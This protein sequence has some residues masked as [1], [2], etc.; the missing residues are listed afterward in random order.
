[1]K[2][3]L[4]FLVGALAC[5][6]LGSGC[7][8]RA[9]TTKLVVFYACGEGAP[10]PE[11][12]ELW[13]KDH[14]KTPVEGVQDNVVVL[15]KRIQRGDR[16]DVFLG[17]GD[18]EC[19]YLKAKGYVLPNSSVRYAGNHIC[20]VI[21]RA[22]NGTVSSLTD[23]EK[24]SV[25]LVA[26]PDPEFNSV[27]A[28]AVAILKREKLWKQVKPKIIQVAKPSEAMMMVQ[29]NQVRARPFNPARSA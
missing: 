19:Q 29:P 23:L 12:M 17:L 2:R 5:T 22:K 13:N 20:V 27:G 15:I 16:A 1:M 25:K 26:L 4:C 24:P 3:G 6:L 11:C 14:K 28:H 9:V 8:R 18:R 21:P 10:I 7:G